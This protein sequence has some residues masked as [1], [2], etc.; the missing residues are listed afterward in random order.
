MKVIF[1]GTPDIAVAPLNGLFEAGYEVAAVLTR[2][3]APVGRKRVLTPSP[4]AARADELGIPVIKA[5]KWSEEVQDAVAAVGADIAAVVAFGVILPPAALELLPQGWINLHFS[6][7]PAWRGAAPVQRALMNGETEIFSST[8]RIE[9][10]LDTGPVFATESATV[11]DKDTAGTMLAR[12]AESGGALL[13]A[14]FA[15]IEK[16][17]TGTPQNGTVTHAAKLTIEDGKIDFD[18]PATEVLAHVRGVTPEPGAWC[19]YKESRLKLGMMKLS[20]AP[21]EGEP[22]ALRLVAKKPVITCGHGTLELTQVQPAGKKMMDAA[23][24]ARGLGAALAE[25]KVVLA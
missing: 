2:E 12:L 15:E 4:V 14:T 7:L 11:G 3:D 24:W 6:A 9:A 5:N 20:E 8:F 25:G 16:G 17:A 21:A 23:D 22:G 18:R 13:A 10:G 19:E 1:A